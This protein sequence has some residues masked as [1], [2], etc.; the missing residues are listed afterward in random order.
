MHSDPEIGGQAGRG[1][2]NIGNVACEP[3]G[4]LARTGAML[5]VGF[6]VNHDEPHVLAPEAETT[7]V[8]RR[9][10]G[11]MRADALENVESTEPYGRVARG[12]PE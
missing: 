1:Q 9:I 2:E 12:H 3:T 4:M 8:L 10:G 6:E 5:D 7:E 11:E